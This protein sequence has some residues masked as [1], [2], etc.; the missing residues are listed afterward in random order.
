[1]K[2]KIIALIIGFSLVAIF[3]I[4]LVSSEYSKVESKYYIH[5]IADGQEVLD[6]IDNNDYDAWKGGIIASLTQENFDKI[7]EYNEY[8]KNLDLL[9]AKINVAWDSK[10]MDEVTRLKEEYHAVVASAKGLTVEEYDALLAEG[11]AARFEK[12]AQAKGM[13][14][15]EYK[16]LMASKKKWSYADLEELA[17]AKG[18]TVQEYKESYFKGHRKG[19]GSKC[20]Y[21]SSWGGKGHHWN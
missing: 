8:E 5:K 14:V 7:V 18:M 21:K 15:E 6:T 17:K 19:F 11:K 12:I 20:G 13:T 1:M 16:E 4:S 3:A 10:D 9:E 2:N